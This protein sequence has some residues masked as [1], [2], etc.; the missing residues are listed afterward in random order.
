MILEAISIA[1]GKELFK[2]VVTDAWKA[3]SANASVKVKQWNTEKKISDLYKKSSNVRRVKTIWQVEKAVD[4]VSFYCDSHVIINK[5][6]KVIDQLDDFGTN[7]N[8]LIEGIA[9]QGKSIFLR[10]LCAVALAQGQCIPI[11]VELR[12]ISEKETLMNRIFE[13]LANLGLSI[14]QAM[15][16]N[17]VASGKITIFLDAFDEIP[18]NLKKRTLSEID[19]LASR[20]DMLR[21]IA[22]S[23]PHNSITMSNYFTNVQLDNLEKDEYKQVIHRLS[24]G[25]DGAES[26]IKHIE[27]RA[28]HIRPLL[29]T[30]LMVTLLVLTYKSHKRLPNRLAGFYDSLFITLLQRHD[31]TKPGFTRHR[32]CDLD[33]EQYRQVFEAL[34]I[35]SKENKE[36]I[37]TYNNLY[38]ITQRALDETHLD[39]SAAKYLD[40]IIKIT[41]LIVHDGDEHRFIHNTVQEYYAAAF[42]A[43]KPDTWARK[44]YKRMASERAFIRWREELFFLREIDRYRYN[45]YFLLP[46]ILNLLGVKENE[47]DRRQKTIT[48]NQIEK[49]LAIFS[50]NLNLAYSKIT[51][52]RMDRSTPI[53]M[54]LLVNKLIYLDYTTTVTAITNGNLKVARRFEKKSQE[55][56]I[57][58]IEIFRAG[59]MKEELRGISEEFINNLFTQAKEIKQRLLSDE[60]DKILTGLI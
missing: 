36:R 20:Y 30:P 8:L 33:D 51:I 42:I 24:R 34:C 59:I 5:S 17:L 18:E 38:K 57:S 4:L 14:D 11:F 29:C 25:D 28:Q 41:C 60:G 45:K 21:I 31:G 52:L 23:R 1:A 53:E 32:A 15:F 13:E 54:Q 39:E 50:V 12:K 3:M 48:V 55:V 44:F 35:I 49:I 56:V 26:L 7:D 27:T 43:K 19:D 10:Y 2:C 46:A 16:H 9:G 58:I 37:F 6:R 40:D 22:T 47:L